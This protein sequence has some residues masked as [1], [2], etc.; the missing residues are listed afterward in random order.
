MNIDKELKR[1]ALK[2]FLR[3]NICVR[4]S[5]YLWIINIKYEKYRNG[6]TKKESYLV[7]YKLN[8]F[9]PLTYI[10]L[11]L[12]TIIGVFEI[13]INDVIIE[14]FELFKYREG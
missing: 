7:Y 9:N 4:L 11:L 2:K 6:F 3:Y 14:S 5:Y 8:P 12:L 10:L 1:I 13:L